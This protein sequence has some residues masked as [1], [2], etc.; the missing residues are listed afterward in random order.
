MSQARALTR[1]RSSRP[2]EF[3]ELQAVPWPAHIGHRD[4]GAGDARHAR[5]EF[6][7][8]ARVER[9]DRD[10]VDAAGVGLGGERRWAGGDVEHVAFLARLGLT[11]EELADRLAHDHEIPSWFSFPEILRELKRTYPP[12][13]R[14]GFTVF[15]TGRVSR[16]CSVPGRISSTFSGTAFIPTAVL[17]SA[18]EI[19]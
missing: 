1:P 2:A 7:G 17:A 10:G 3:D 16:G 4:F 19:T 6:V 8:R 18:S 12:R 5:G 9:I 11:D 15:F 14:Q 13:S